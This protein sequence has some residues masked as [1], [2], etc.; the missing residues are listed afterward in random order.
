M[1]D[2]TTAKKLNASINVICRF[3][4]WIGLI[5]MALSE[6]FPLFVG[7]HTACLTVLFVICRAVYKSAFSVGKG[8]RADKQYAELA[9]APQAGL[10][11]AVKSP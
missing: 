9:L 4:C 3:P 7:S 2:I 10:A 1:H 8:Y 6:V 5:G 11:F